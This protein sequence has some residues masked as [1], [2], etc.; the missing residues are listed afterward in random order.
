MKK[1][2]KAYGGGRPY[3]PTKKK[4]LIHIKPNASQLYMRKFTEQQIP[5]R[6]WFETLKS[7]DGKV[8]EVETKFLFKDQF[9]TTNG[10]RI[11]EESVSK[12]IND[13]RKNPKYKDRMFK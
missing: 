3:N 7:V 1:K 2:F 4:M 12:I 13:V 11:M 10:L 8:L 5:N 9:N 6:K